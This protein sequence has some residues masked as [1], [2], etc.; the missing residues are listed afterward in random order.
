[1][2]F[3]KTKKDLV[4]L[5]R[6]CCLFGHHCHDL[7]QNL[8]TEKYWMCHVFNEIGIDV[9]IGG[10]FERIPMPV[11]RRSIAFLVAWVQ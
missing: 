7:A 6:Q 4:E 1:M 9:A 2:V 5:S 3:P 11:G 8:M 10:D